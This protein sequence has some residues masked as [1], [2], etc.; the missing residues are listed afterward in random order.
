MVTLTGILL[1]SI[2]HSSLH[3][4]FFGIDGAPTLALKAYYSAFFKRR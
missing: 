1:C 3:E 2:F 4:L